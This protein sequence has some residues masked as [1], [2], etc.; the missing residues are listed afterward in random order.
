[1]IETRDFQHVPCQ[2]HLWFRTSFLSSWVAYS[3]LLVPP[4]H[5]F[6]SAHPELLHL[7][8]LDSA[9]VHGMAHHASRA[10]SGSSKG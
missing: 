3:L 6:C 1:M 4:L 10:F 7:I 5:I 9:M 2:S 8:L